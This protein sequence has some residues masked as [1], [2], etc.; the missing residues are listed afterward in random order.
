MT[1]AAIKTT[2]PETVAFIHVRGPYD[3]IPQAMR[4]LYGWVERHDLTATGMPEA[5]YLTP[6][7]DTPSSVA[8]W[9]L[10]APVGDAEDMEPDG[11]GIG[12]K[13]VASH[14]VA[15]AMHRGPYE[16]IGQTYEQLGNWIAANGY[17][18]VGPSEEVY[19]SDPKEIPPDEYLTE[20][21][22]PVAGV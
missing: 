15:S 5:V 18:I 3:K 8:E 14:M 22:F 17:S 16:T 2:A 20:I 21:R 1:A 13:H 7:G 11:T 12:I 9:E 4:A 10:Y 19:Y 6:P